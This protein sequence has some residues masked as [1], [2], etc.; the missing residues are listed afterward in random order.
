MIKVDES[1]PRAQHC[2]SFRG[3]L[4]CFCLKEKPW[5]IIK[6]NAIP[7]HP[8]WSGTSP[9]LGCDGFTQQ[10]FRGPDPEFY[11]AQRECD[12]LAFMLPFLTGE[13]VWIPIMA[14]SQAPPSTLYKKEA[15]QNKQELMRNE[16]FEVEGITTPKS[17]SLSSLNPGSNSGCYDNMMQLCIIMTLWHNFQKTVSAVLFCCSTAPKET[18]CNLLLWHNLYYWSNRSYGRGHKKPNYGGNQ[19]RKNIGLNLPFIQW[20][21]ISYFE[22]IRN[23]NVF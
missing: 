11:L 1:A 12:D 6:K 13:G 2:F 21:L 4:G 16:I 10:W 20:D 23:W 15:Q 8:P 3:R 9:A 18:C 7:L 19:R 5:I 17:I 22:G 14:S